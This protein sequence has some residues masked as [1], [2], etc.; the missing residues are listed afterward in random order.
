MRQGRVGEGVGLHHLTVGQSFAKA[1]THLVYVA[2]SHGPLTPHV[3]SDLSAQD[4]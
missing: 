1:E 4:S 3:L 2:E